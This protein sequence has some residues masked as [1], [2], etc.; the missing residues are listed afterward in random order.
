MKLS[1]N[2]SNQYGFLQLREDGAI[3]GERIYIPQH[4]QAWV[5]RIAVESTDAH[6]TGGFAK[7]H[8]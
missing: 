1:N 6:D 2:V 8:S 3:Q 7:I 4:P 5:K